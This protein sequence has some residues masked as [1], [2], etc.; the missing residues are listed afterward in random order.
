MGLIAK[1]L[2]SFFDHTVNMINR[3]SLS[4]HITLCNK[5]FFGVCIAFPLKT[6]EGETRRLSPACRLRKFL[7]NDH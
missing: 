2:A 7:Q 4:L 1:I 3:F 6:K 5:D